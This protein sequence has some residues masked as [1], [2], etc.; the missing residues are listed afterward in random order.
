MKQAQDNLI[1]ITKHKALSKPS[2]EM[3]LGIDWV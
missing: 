1:K 2:C 3:E